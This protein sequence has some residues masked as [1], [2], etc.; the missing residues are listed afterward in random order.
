MEEWSDWARKG[1]TVNVAINVYICTKMEV[2]LPTGW[3]TEGDEKIP[4]PLDQ[5]LRHD[6]CM[7]EIF[8]QDR[9]MGERSSR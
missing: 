5:K 1:P 7:G 4:I 6:R 2:I 3:D 9:S 8:L